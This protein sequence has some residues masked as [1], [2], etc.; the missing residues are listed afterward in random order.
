[1]AAARLCSRV[2]KEREPLR[3]LLGLQAASVGSAGGSGCTVSETV[4]A[5]L[6]REAEAPMHPS[7]QT[8]D[9]RHQCRR[10]WQ[11]MQACMCT[12]QGPWLF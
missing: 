1:M 12:I 4:S 7:G 10:Q 11:E 2:A 5:L 9:T 8:T 6:G 3:W